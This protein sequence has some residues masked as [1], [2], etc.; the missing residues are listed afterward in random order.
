MKIINKLNK[1]FNMNRIIINGISQEVSGKNIS[2]QIVVDGKVVA[3]NLSGDINLKF[4]GD[5]ANLDCTSVTVN[6]NVNGTLDCTSATISGDVTGDV[7]CT[8]INCGNITGNVDGTTVTCGD[9]G[10]DV[11][12]IKIIKK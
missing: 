1:I 2:V 11:D 5:L 6:G 7:D 3:Q 4:E 10:G 8:S 9:I 12:A